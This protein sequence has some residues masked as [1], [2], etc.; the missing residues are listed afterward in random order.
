MGVLQWKLSLLC[1]IAEIK[2][3]SFPMLAIYNEII[4]LCFPGEMIHRN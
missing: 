4:F 3:V 1:N 2:M